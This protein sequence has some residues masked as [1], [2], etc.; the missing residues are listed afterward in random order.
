MPSARLAAMTH[1]FTAAGPRNRS[2]PI[3]RGVAFTADDRFRGEIIE[4]LMCDLEVD[5]MAMCARH[6]RNVA[7]LAHELSVLDGFEHDGL[8]R[9]DSARL[10]VTEAG[11]VLV[12]SV[13]AVFDTRLAPDSRTP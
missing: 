7:D 5:L 4:R 9:H 6:G 1:A 11:R 8:V 3:A 2:Q 10:M 12:R 13:C